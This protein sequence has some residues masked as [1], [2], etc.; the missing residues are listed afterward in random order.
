MLDLIRILL[1]LFLIIL[2]LRKKWHIGVVMSLGA[3]LLALFYLMPPKK[4]ITESFKTLTSP[5]SL[6]L[7]LALSFIRSFEMI[8]REKGLLQKITEA[9]G[10]ILK[11]RKLVIISMPLL[12]GMLPSL[13]G[14]Y[15]SAPMVEESSRDLNL[16]SEHKAYINYWFRHPWE[17]ILP[18]YPGI[19]LASAV[20]NIP[21]RSFIAANML[22]AI[23][24]VIAG[25]FIGLKD[26]RG[27][28]QSKIKKPKLSDVLL[29]LMPVIAVIGGVSLFGIELHQ[30]LIGILILLIIFYKES[31][32][33]IF[34]LLKYGFSKDV[35]LLIAG[36]ML[37]KGMMEASGAV[38]GLDRY[39]VETGVPVLLIAFILPF[40]AG[41]LTG[42]VVGFIGS[43]FPLLIA[44]AGK[45]LSILAFAF[46]SGYAGVLLSP[47]HL[48]LVLTREYFK[49]DMAGVYKRLLPGIMLMLLS[50][51]AVYY[52]FKS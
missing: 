44:M 51:I 40:I 38:E 5:V 7:L 47:V 39:F 18:L 1:V 6:K 45:D 37:L 12:I 27:S 9:T 49:A 50:S 15:F 28:I 52:A 10:S 20:T 13:G 3:F 14:A 16:T 34:S 25:F 33:G 22:V 36:V 29:P 31:F 21:L 30:V 19:V 4:I 32:K 41:L 8:L 42:L 43:T 11:K 17:L 24:M 48:C 26:I 35:F 23:T 2:F 46:V